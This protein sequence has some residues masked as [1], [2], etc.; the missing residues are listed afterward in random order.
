MRYLPILLVSLALLAVVVLLSGDT[1]RGKRAV[2]KIVL[3]LVV[4]L[5]LAGLFALAV[6]RLV[7]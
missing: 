1:E 3:T 4:L 6:G 7:P 2:G 5:G